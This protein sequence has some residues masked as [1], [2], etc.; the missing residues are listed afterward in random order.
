M[1]PA[2]APQAFGFATPARAFAFTAQPR[3][4]TFLAT[5]TGMTAIAINQGAVVIRTLEK[6]IG[7]QLN[8]SG[9]LQGGETISTAV[10]TVKAVLLSTPTTDLSANAAAMVQGK[11]IRAW[12]VGK[13]RLCGLSD[14]ARSGYAWG[15]RPRSGAYRRPVPPACCWPT[16]PGTR[17]TRHRWRRPRPR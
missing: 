10:P 3:A 6:N 12:N 1:L 13:S 8:F 7:Y 5:G 2:P 4:F 14:H 11:R 16:P 17:R 9:W 15:H